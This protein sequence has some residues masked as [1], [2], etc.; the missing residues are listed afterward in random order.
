LRKV[1]LYGSGQLGVMAAYILGYDEDVE[2]VG[3]VDDDPAKLEQ[4]SNGLKV[5]GDGSVLPELR[6][7]G[8][9]CTIACI[10]DN[11]QRGIVARRLTQ[12]GFELISAIHPTA[13]I[14][15]RASLSG[16][17]I[18]GPGAI[19]SAHSSIGS[20]PYIGAGTVIG[21]DVTV[22]DNALISVGCVIAARVD[23]EDE[24]FIGGGARLVPAEMGQENRLRIGKGAVIGA[25]AV[26]IADVPPY[27]VAVGVPAKVVRYRENT[28]G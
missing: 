27:A 13:N 1:V 15:R 18:V 21:H 5:L 24:A 14:S 22:G 3:F 16:G 11:H 4:E 2:V 28:E 6:Q 19:I 20:S 8:V 10:G 17:A 7:A 23:I 12:M 9:T 25:G 26:V